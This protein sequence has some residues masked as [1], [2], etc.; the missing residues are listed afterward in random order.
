MITIMCRHNFPQFLKITKKFH[1]PSE[2]LVL[3]F[4]REIV[5]VLY[6]KYFSSHHSPGT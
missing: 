1:C 3:H 4:Y 2:Q 6:E 5:T